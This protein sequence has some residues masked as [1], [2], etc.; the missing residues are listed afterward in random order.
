MLHQVHRCMYA[1]QSVAYDA[2]LV[3]EEWLCVVVSPKLCSAF[4]LLKELAEIP[5]HVK[6]VRRKED[7][8]VVL[9]TPVNASSAI[10]SVM[11]A[12]GFP[13]QIASVVRIPLTRPVAKEQL[14]FYNAMWPC[15]FYEVIPDTKLLTV[16]M[17]KEFENFMRF[18]ISERKEIGCVIVNWTTKQ[19]VASARHEACS[20][21]GHAVVQGLFLFG[22]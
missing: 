17:E 18:A 5:K 19:I 21:G 11:G 3:V 15:Q 7:V 4:L 13:E 9:V 10:A 12:T 14:P 20:Y 16:E 8:C 2:P 22:V 6:R 1:V